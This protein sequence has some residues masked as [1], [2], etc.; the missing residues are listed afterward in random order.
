MLF[1]ELTLEINKSG[2]KKLK[3]VELKQAI[4]ILER[5]NTEKKK[6]IKIS[7]EQLKNFKKYLLVQGVSEDTEHKRFYQEQEKLLSTIKWLEKRFRMNCINEK[8]MTVLKKSGVNQV[9]NQNK[10]LLE[11][12]NQLRE[13]GIIY[14]NE[15]DHL[16]KKLAEANMIIELEK[17]V[18]NQDRSIIKQ[19]EKLN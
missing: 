7:I 18:S 10:N 13:E 15:I 2:A 5:E 17:K 4:K 9:V 16:S 12:C 3:L 19:S 6:N 8:K 1:E 14:E 11:E